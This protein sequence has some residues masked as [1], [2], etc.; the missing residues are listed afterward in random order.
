MKKS[1]LN[2]ARADMP[3]SNVPFQEVKL[4]FMHYYSGSMIDKQL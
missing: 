1:D 3:Y 2:G 4:S